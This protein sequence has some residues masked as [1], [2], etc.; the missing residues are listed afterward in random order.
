MKVFSLSVLSL[1]ASELRSGGVRIVLANGCFDVMHHGHTEHLRSAKRLGD[2]LMVTV[3]QDAHVNKGPNRPVF[4]VVERCRMLAAL[5]CVDYVTI[6]TPTPGEAILMLKPHLYVKGP[7]YRDNMTQPLLIEKDAV[8][9]VGGRLVFTDDPQC[10]S[11][12][13]LVK[14]KGAD[15]GR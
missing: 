5:E 12:D 9:S 4:G 2:V 13:V 14:L 1:I 11:T 6:N 10:H 3:T 15:H 7:E 8:E